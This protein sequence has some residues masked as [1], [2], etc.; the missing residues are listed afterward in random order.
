MSFEKAQT[1]KTHTKNNNNR[2]LIWKAP[3]LKHL[4]VI[5]VSHFVINEHY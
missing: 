3:I 5:F 2:Q 4:V 1:M